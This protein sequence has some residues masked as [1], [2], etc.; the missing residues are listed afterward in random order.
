[1]IQ[2]LKP[3]QEYLDRYD[4][5]TVEDCRR[6][7][8]F[9]NNVGEAKSDLE[10]SARGLVRD[11]GLY[12][13]LLYATL[14]WY[15]DKENTVNKWMD[16]D[17]RKDELL[18]HAQPPEGVRCLKCYSLTTC[19]DKSIHDWGSDGRDR[20]LFMFDCPAGCVPHRAFF[21]D[22]EEYRIKPDLCPNCQTELERTSERVENK[23]IVT[24]D[25]CPKCGYI[26]TDEMDLTI[27][28]EK[29][30]PDFL[31][32]RARFCL[33]KGE[34]DKKREEKWR[35]EEM[36]KLSDKLKED[37]LHEKEREAVKKLRKLTVLDLEKVLVPLSEK[38]G[39]VRLQFGNPDL[40]RD[41]M[42]PFTA[43]DSKS[44]QTEGFSTS[45]L[46]KIIKKAL[47]DTNWRLMS[48]GILYRLGI[49]SGRLRAYEL[50]E[51]L[52]K[53]VVQNEK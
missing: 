4:R 6:R 22:G 47:A 46:Q 3:K 28:E 9:H 5:I 40:G 36:G 35:A 41:L 43:H 45:E 12:F 49:L 14:H 20:V 25:T 16:S 42:V 23:K 50:E 39:Y 44:D 33:T 38:A 52:L 26:N 27:K 11:L 48:D 19:S 31:K 2:H 13:D 1:M 7:E 37:T 24:T 51:D 53:L 8:K 34:A 30:D 17:L 15:D 18:E 32:D 29:P 21:D 10:K